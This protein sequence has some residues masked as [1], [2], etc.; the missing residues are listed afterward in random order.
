M[1]SRSV[2]DRRQP[3]ASKTIY[4]PTLNS[5]NRYIDQFSTMVSKK[6]KRTKKTS[7]KQKEDDIVLKNL[8]QLM[9]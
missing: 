8:N 3:Q 6:V 5:R 7:K 1:D 9:N 2:Y 4:E